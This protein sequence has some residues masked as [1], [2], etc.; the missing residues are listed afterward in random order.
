MLR[1]I[2]IGLIAVV[3]AFAL[4]SLARRLYLSD[5]QGV[6]TAL[7]KRSPVS[8]EQQDLSG[9]S[10]ER[11]FLPYANFRRTKLNETILSDANLQYADFSGAD[12][13]MV[14]ASSTDFS[15]AVFHDAKLRHA[16]WLESAVFRHANFRQT[17]LSWVSF[18]GLYGRNLRSKPRHMLDPGYGGADLTGARFDGAI[19]QNTFFSRCLLTGASFRGADCRDADFS[20]ADLRNADFT[21]ADLRGARLKGADLT[22]AIL[23]NVKK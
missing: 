5:Y 22:G 11:A 16:R 9:Q 8:H 17:D 10:F 15:H 2:V 23:F 6:R 14:G 7:A 19:C 4:Y 13:E 3:A 20:N 1:N 18:H 12:F 21:N